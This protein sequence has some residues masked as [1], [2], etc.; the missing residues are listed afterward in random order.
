L[1]PDVDW[2]KLRDEYRPQAMNAKSADELAAVLKATLGHLEDEQIWIEMPN[3]DRV[4]TYRTAWSYNGNRKAVLAQL[5]L[6]TECGEYAV[7]GRTWR[8]GFGYFLMTRQSAA[9]PELVTKAVAA[10]KEVANRPGFVIDLRGANG[11]KE[12]SAQE[13]A[14][15]IAQQF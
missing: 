12:S 13:F 3:G 8:D 5:E 10:I 11:G 9:A 7:V 2:A 4:D 6:S 14:R 15:E 1:K